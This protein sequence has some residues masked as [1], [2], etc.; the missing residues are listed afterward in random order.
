MEESNSSNLSEVAKTVHKVL[1]PFYTNVVRQTSKDGKSLKDL[2]NKIAEYSNNLSDKSLTAAEK[3]FFESQLK[4]LVL[5]A[6][7][8]I[9][10]ISSE[11]LDKKSN[12]Q[13]AQTDANVTEN[14][15]AGLK[16][17]AMRAQKLIE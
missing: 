15:L 11:V 12:N 3:D 10:N 14:F 2:L 17:E 7:D 6:I 4:P 9:M 5:D 13:I 16:R 1:T 8:Y